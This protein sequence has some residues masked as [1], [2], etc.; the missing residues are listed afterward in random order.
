MRAVELAARLGL[1][2]EAVARKLLPH[3][4]R[5]GTE[6][7]AGGLSGDAGDA[8]GVDVRG[9]GAGMWNDCT[10]GE[11]GDLI[12]LWMLTQDVT[13]GEACAQA[14]EYLGLHKDRPRHIARRYPKPDRLEV[15]RPSPEHADW[16]RNERKIPGATIASYRLA[17]K[18]E[19]L[20]FPYLRPN[21]KAENGFDLVSARYRQR[22]P[23]GAE[24]FSC[25]EGCEPILFGWQAVPSRARTV[26]LCANEMDALAWHAY[27]YPAL[28]MPSGDD[29]LKWIESEFVAIEPYDTIYLSI[30][31]EAA[32]RMPLSKLVERLGRERCRIVKLPEKTAGV[33]LMRD[34]PAETMA[35]AIKA[36]RTLDPCELRNTGEFEDAVVAEISRVDSGLLLPWPKT[37]ARF[38]LRPAEVSI[39][40]GANGHGKTVTVSQIIGYQATRGTRCCVASMEWPTP[41]WLLRMQRQIGAVEIPSEEY[42]RSLTQKLAGSIW[43][44]DVQRS[45]KAPRILEVFDYARRRYQ[46]EL[47]LIDNLTKCGFADDDFAGQKNFVEALADF[48]R[49]TRSHVMLVAHMKKGQSEDE[50]SGKWGVKG[51]GGIT[52]MAQTVVEIW[53][54]KARERAKEVAD[55]DGVPLPEKYAEGGVRDMDMLLKVHKQNE[56]GDEPQWSFWHDQRTGQFVGSPHEQPK[57]ML[58]VADATFADRMAA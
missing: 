44:F 28:A 46:V 1:Q 45:A 35:T 34:V 19:R 27:G 26:C 14:T 17:S 55:R 2:A 18:G 32:E 21:A 39:W 52:D 51:S 54:N 15:T 12:D 24:R 50:L 5:H 6:W 25:D 3:G 58:P 36:A 48:A 22:S 56:T 38:K 4:R 9:T 10:T 57:P 8:L 11:A 20:M 7:R 47:F 42:S 49:D 37:H 43:T 41:R 23:E 40:A 53:R 31:Q 16:L 33:C 13:L 30:E 29:A